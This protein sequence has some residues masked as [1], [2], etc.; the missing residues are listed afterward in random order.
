MWIGFQ[1]LQ[2]RNN[3]R[4]TQKAG[5]SRGIPLVLVG[6]HRVLLRGGTFKRAYRS[7]TIVGRSAPAGYR[8]VKRRACAHENRLYRFFPSGIS[9]RKTR[10]AS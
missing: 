3:T 5:F 1:C 7:G 6:L 8:A 9:F 2:S 4:R 10:P